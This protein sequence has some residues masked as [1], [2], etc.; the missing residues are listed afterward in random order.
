MKFGHFS[1]SRG[2]WAFWGYVSSTNTQKS[3]RMVELVHESYWKLQFL[4]E[5]TQNFLYFELSQQKIY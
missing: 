3:T 1:W 4:K 2:K 5:K